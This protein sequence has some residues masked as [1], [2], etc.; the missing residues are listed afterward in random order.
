M[1]AYSKTGMPCYGIQKPER[2]DSKK[3]LPTMIKSPET[4]KEYVALWDLPHREE[5]Y[6]A[7]DPAMKYET[8]ISV[9]M[10]GL[11]ENM[12]GEEY[13]WWDFVILLPSIKSE[14]V[15]LQNKGIPTLQ[16][17]LHR[18]I[19]DDNKWIRR[20]AILAQIKHKDSTDLEMQLQFC[21]LTRRIF[22]YVKP[23]VGR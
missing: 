5:K 23:L 9:D 6:L 13:M 4:Y 22:S 7:I 19:R 21:A 16:A 8:F 18:W 1:K 10:I 15:L 3:K 12:I 20:R 17:I 11:Y 14:K 2:E